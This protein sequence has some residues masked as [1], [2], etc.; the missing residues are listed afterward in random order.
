MKSNIDAA[1]NLALRESDDAELFS[2]VEIIY[3][4]MPFVPVRTFERLSDQFRANMDA[5]RQSGALPTIKAVPK[6]EHDEPLTHVTADMLFES[7]GESARTATPEIEDAVAAQPPH[8]RVLISGISGSGKTTLSERRR[9][10]LE[11]ENVLFISPAADVPTVIHSDIPDNFNHLVADDVTLLTHEN[12][13]RL[14]ALL[15]RIIRTEGA[16]FTVAADPALDPP[17][18]HALL[19]MVRKDDNIIWYEL[20]ASRRAQSRLAASVLPKIRAGLLEERDNPLYARRIDAALEKYAFSKPLEELLSAPA[21]LFPPGD[22]SA[23]LV[24]V[25]PCEAIEISTALRHKNIEH[26]FLT[27]DGEAPTVNKG[28]LTIA[29]A[30]VRAEFDN[31]YLLGSVAQ[32]GFREVYRALSKTRVSFRVIRREKCPDFLLDGE[33][34]LLLSHLTK[35]GKTVCGGIFAG[36]KGDIDEEGFSKERQNQD[37][38]D[39]ITRHVKRGDKVCVKRGYG[40]EYNIYHG[41]IRIGSMTKQFSQSVVRAVNLAETGKVL[42]SGISGLFVDEIHVTDDTDGI[43]VKIFGLGKCEHKYYE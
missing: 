21:R 36:L 30:G 14:L 27:D 25:N 17:F 15:S 5:T 23:A 38:R 20:P 22:E 9:R 12:Q 18:F 8:S 1:S 42:P 10:V 37:T 34:P 4:T 31:V 19:N 39:Y 3:G 40:D 24:A 28:V 7:H 29:T 33:R 16:G 32:Y 2:E 41:D 43:Y 13:K 35:S 26:D 11:G 6:P